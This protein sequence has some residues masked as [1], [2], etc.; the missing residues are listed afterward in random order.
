MQAEEKKKHI[1]PVFSESIINRNVN[2]SNKAALG[3]NS[4]NYV[5][6]K[7]MENIIFKGGGSLDSS[8]NLRMSNMVMREIKTILLTVT[9]LVK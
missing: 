8:K 3:S 7:K 9:M 2:S 1:K 5:F 6:F 4:W